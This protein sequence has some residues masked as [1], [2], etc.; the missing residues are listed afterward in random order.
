MHERGRG[1]GVEA[2]LQPLRDAAEEGACGAMMVSD[3]E[4]TTCL[5]ALISQH[6]SRRAPDIPDSSLESAGQKRSRTRSP[7]RPQ[8]SQGVEARTQGRACG[9]EFLQHLQQRAAL[10]VPRLV[11]RLALGREQRVQPRVVGPG[12]KRA[13]RLQRGLADGAPQVHVARQRRAQ[14]ERPLCSA[15]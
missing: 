15:G 12:R 9:G 14:R 13:Q 4:M 2:R 11:L 6:I 10:L 7:P 5:E 1:D 3:K 8:G